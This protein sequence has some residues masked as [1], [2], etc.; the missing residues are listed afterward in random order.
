MKLCMKFPAHKQ[1]F[2]VCVQYS[3]PRLFPLL[4]H[5]FLT[6]PV[7]VYL[8]VCFGSVSFGMVECGQ[9]V[10]LNASEV[11]GKRVA[12]V[13]VCSVTRLEKHSRAS[14]LQISVMTAGDGKMM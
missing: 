12:A 6:A 3:P 13:C 14:L 4:S 8:C 5:C 1:W 2:L 7:S 11:R 10:P 9:T